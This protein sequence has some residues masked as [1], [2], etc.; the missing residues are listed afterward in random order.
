MIKK[1]S[2]VDHLSSVVWWCPW[3]SSEPAAFVVAD[4][5]NIFSEKEVHLE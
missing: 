1:D 2:S 5:M 4:Q 3:T